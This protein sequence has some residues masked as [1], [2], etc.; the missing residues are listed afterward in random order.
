MQIAYINVQYTGS[1]ITCGLKIPADA[2]AL[3]VTPIEVRRERREP[4]DGLYEYGAYDIES[5]VKE[6]AGRLRFELLGAWDPQS[7]LL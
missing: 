4:N 6:Q 3:G 7:R 1:K 5:L 2:H